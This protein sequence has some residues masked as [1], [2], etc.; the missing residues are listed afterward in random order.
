M[1]Y[2]FKNSEMKWKPLLKGQI[3]MLNLKQKS[4]S[5]LLYRNGIVFALFFKKRNVSFEN[6]NRKTSQSKSTEVMDNTF[7]HF[8]DQIF[9]SECDFYEEYVIGTTRWSFF[10]YWNHL[11]FQVWKLSHKKLFRI[12]EITAYKMPQKTSKF[13][14]KKVLFNKILLQIFNGNSQLIPYSN[15]NL[16][17]RLNR[18]P[19]FSFCKSNKLKFNQIICR[20]KCVIA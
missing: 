2:Q 9:G 12:V 19:F 16:I 8:F 6:K 18:I 1:F 7:F 3:M 10:V 4:Y 5:H 20:C 15:P 17:A 11:I 13:K 14:S